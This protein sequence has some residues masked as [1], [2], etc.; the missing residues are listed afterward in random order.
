MRREST[1]TQNITEIDS[2]IYVGFS[3]HALRAWRRT[4]TGPA[5]IRVGRS[6]RYAAKDL[7]DWL[8]KHRVEP[9]ETRTGLTG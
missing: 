2:S 9:R 6:I 8:L 1:S 7:D 4:G 5:Y 3:V